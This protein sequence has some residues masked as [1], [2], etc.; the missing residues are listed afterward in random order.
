M[1]ERFLHLRERFLHIRERFL[2]LPERFLHL[3]ER[4]LH[5]GERFLHLP[6]RF[7]HLRERFLHLREWFLHIRE[8]FCQMQSVCRGLP[9]TISGGARPAVYVV[10]KHG[11]IT[12]KWE[13]ELAY[14]GATGEKQLTNAIDRA[15]SN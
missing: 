7:L 14:Q 4:F 11:R 6:E 5:I 13:G 8:R 1:R 3:P 12:F 2:H 10:D 15:L 9:R